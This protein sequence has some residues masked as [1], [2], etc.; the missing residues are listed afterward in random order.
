M[1]KIFVFNGIH[2]SGKTTLAKNLVLQYPD[3]YAF[4]SE[5]GRKLREEV[6]YNSL[7]SGEDFDREVMR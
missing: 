2:G 7:E 4:Y 5:I 1:K 6:N 3:T